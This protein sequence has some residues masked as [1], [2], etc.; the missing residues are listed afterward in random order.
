MARKINTEGL[1]HIMQWEG[2]KL[3]ACNTVN[4]PL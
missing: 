2:L 4:T 1:R 3:E